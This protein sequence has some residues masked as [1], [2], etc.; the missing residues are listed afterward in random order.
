MKDSYDVLFKRTI[1]IMK[2]FSF[3]PWCRIGSRDA[4]SESTRSLCATESRCYSSCKSCSAPGRYSTLPQVTGSAHRECNIIRVIS[5]KSRRAIISRVIA[6]DWVTSLLLGCAQS[7][8]VFFLRLLLL[9]YI[10]FILWCKVF[11]CT[12]CLL[13]CYYFDI[14]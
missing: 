14:L 2:G 9:V 12:P 4:S 5:V 8:L 3:P 13:V 1:G 10:L 6:R 7:P 11:V